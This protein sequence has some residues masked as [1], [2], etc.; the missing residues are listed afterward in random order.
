MS[1]VAPGFVG[2]GT[3]VSIDTT[4]ACDQP[5]REPSMPEVLPGTTAGDIVCFVA[6]ILIAIPTIIC[7][8]FQW[9]LWRQDKREAAEKAWG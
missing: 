1:V 8:T 9:C 7:L 3:C 2:E 6:M 4:D 5:L